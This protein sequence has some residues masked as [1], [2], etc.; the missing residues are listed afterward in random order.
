MRERKQTAS[1]FAFASAHATPTNSH[2]T[3]LSP[4]LVPLLICERYQ[5][6]GHISMA[7]IR[8]DKNDRR[9]PDGVSRGGRDQVSSCVHHVLHCMVAQPVCIH[10]SVARLLPLPSVP[11]SLPV[12]VGQGEGRQGPRVLPRELALRARRPLA[13]GEGP[14]VVHQAKQER[15]RWYVRI[16]H[17]SRIAA[18]RFRLQF[19]L[20]ILHLTHSQRWCEGRIRSQNRSGA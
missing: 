11:S 6:G 12:F 19:A 9:L 5:G 1:P 4:L 17:A 16:T 3:L 18:S 2:S 7:N 13:T 15:R 10:Y 8:L 20:L 14:A